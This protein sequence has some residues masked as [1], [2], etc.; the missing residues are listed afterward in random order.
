MCND[1]LARTTL[2]RADLTALQLNAHSQLSKPNVSKSHAQQYKGLRQGSTSES[3]VLGDFYQHI[4]DITQRDDFIADS[5]LLLRNDESDHN[6]V[7]YVNH[8][9]EF[10]FWDYRHWPA[11]RQHLKGRLDEMSSDEELSEDIKYL[12]HRVGTPCEKGATSD[13]TKVK[14]SLRARRRRR[15]GHVPSDDEDD[16]E[17]DYVDIV[18]HTIFST[19]KKTAFTQYPRYLDDP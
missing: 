15:R 8:D 4:E 6:V 1:K 17:S 16:D 2:K 13:R 10:E 9:L 7:L 5:I 11:N 12:G 18:P 14:A 3:A 19:R